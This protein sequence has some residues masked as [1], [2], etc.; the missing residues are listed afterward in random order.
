VHLAVFNGSEIFLAFFCKKDFAIFEDAD[1]K[2]TGP[3]SDLF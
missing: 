3:Y 2:G 1:N